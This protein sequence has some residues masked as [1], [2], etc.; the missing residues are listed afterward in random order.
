VVVSAYVLGY[1]GFLLLVGRAAD[2]LGRRRV[3][4]V[5]L[6]VFVG[7]SALGGLATSGT[8]LVVTR[9]VKGLSAAFTAPAS[10]PVASS[11]SSHRIA[12][13]VARF[14]VARLVVGG[15]VSIGIGYVLFLRVGLD[16]SYAVEM[17]PTFILAGLGFG[18]AF[19][20]LNI[21]AT[22][23]VAAEEEGLAG[24]PE[25]ILTGLHAALFV[26]IAAVVLGIAAVLRR[27]PRPAQAEEPAEL[28]E[29]LE[30][31]A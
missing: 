20:P 25:S 18:L 2:L 7:A 14:G 28:D 15:L 12:P 26:V 9:F 31:A 8:L 29:A 19:G 3:F 1:G 22:R 4:L 21:A 27:G 24:A 17:P 23:G 6:G 30:E 16:S 5:S 10:R 13:L 11:R